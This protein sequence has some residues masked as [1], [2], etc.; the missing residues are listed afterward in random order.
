MLQVWATRL[1]LQLLPLP[2]YGP[3]VPFYWWFN[4]ACLLLGDLAIPPTKPPPSYGPGVPFCKCADAV[5]MGDLAIPSTMPLPLSGPGVPCRGC[6]ASLFLG[7]PAIPSTLLL[8]LPGL[9]CPAQ[10]VSS[11]A[12]RLSLHL[13]RLLHAAI[14]CINVAILVSGDLAI[15]PAMP[16]PTPGSGVPC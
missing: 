12:T 3:G 15:P 11:W 2:S 16:H 5:S 8:L 6:A 1:S 10:Q 9:A 13:C 4:A 7:D 14:T